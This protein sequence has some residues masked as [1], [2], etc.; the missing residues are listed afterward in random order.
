MTS[1]IE[2]VE[3]SKGRVGAEWWAESLGY[4]REGRVGYV[5]CNKVEM[6]LV[7]GRGE[8]RSVD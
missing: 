6:V 5:D 8:G 7:W 2:R 1:R 3:S 4:V